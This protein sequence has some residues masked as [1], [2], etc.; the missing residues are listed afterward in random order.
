MEVKMEEG[1]RSLVFSM[2][3]KA[4]LLDR[5]S[6]VQ[7]VVTPQ[8]EFGMGITVSKDIQKYCPSNAKII[9]IFKKEG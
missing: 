9:L 3:E 2:K 6:T 7:T 5:K 4:R 8:W 1:L